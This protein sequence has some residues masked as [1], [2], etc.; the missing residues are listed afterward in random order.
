MLFRSKGGR[1]NNEDSIYP[2]PE[3]IRSNQSLFLVCDGVGGAEKGEVAS[4]LACEAFQSYFTTFL[5]GNPTEEFIQKAIRYTESRFDDYTQQHPHAKGMAT[6]LAM[7]YLG[8]N[9]I[10]IGHIGDSRIYLFR[11]GEIVYRTEDHSLINSWIKLGKITP[12]QALNHP[13]RHV[14]LKAI[15]SVEQQVEIDVATIHSPEPGDVLFICS[16]GVLEQ[17]TDEQLSSIFSRCHHAETIKNEIMTHCSG[18]T[19]DNYSFYIIPI[20]NVTEQAGLKQNLLS[21]FYSFV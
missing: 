9:G 1:L 8:D 12:E 20:E 17:L 21:L 13:Q 6:T 19:R 15:Q 3:S 5:S 4:A 10:T 14:I 18:R 16:D 11:K 2:Q 7:V